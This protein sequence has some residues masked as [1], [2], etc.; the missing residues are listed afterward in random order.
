MEG[1]VRCDTIHAFRDSKA[2]CG[3]PCSAILYQRA[4][5]V[6]GQVSAAE[7]SLSNVMLDG[8]K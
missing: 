8:Y 6:E 1:E 3:S 4:L 7:N 5:G 2:H